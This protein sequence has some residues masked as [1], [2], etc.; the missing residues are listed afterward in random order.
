MNVTSPSSTHSTQSTAQTLPIKR[1]TDTNN[2]S[3]ASKATST[4]TPS[5]NPPYLGNSIDTKA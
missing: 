5:S 4:P 1:S 2:T 3:G